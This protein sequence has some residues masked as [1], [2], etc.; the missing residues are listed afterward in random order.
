MRSEQ[1]CW[2]TFRIG[3]EEGYGART[4]FPGSAFPVDALSALT[5][6]MA[7]RFI[8]TSE[9]AVAALQAAVEKIGRCVLIG[10]SQGG[11]F[12]A[13]VASAAPGAVLAT[14]LLEPHGLPARAAGPQ[15]LVMG[16]NIERS[17]I[18]AQLAP[19]WA[20]YRATGPQ[21]DVMDLPSLGQRG[22]SHAMMADLNS[23]AVSAL[24]RE[25]IE[26]TLTT[27]T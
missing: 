26:K 15:L 19:L 7:P 2:T 13:R 24:I 12:A 25:W 9:L 27:S 22:N 14:V 23:E 10:H 21:V 6:Q 11:G 20:H 8:T 4:A 3:P 5:R 1:E 18:T 17:E 16:D